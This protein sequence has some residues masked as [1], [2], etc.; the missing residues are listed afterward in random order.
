VTGFESVSL[1]NKAS[2]SRRLCV[3]EWLHS[4][5]HF[6][7]EQPEHYQEIHDLHEQFYRLASGVLASAL[8]GRTNEAKRELEAPAF[9][10]VNAALRAASTTTAASA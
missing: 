3:W 4:A 7:A 5:G 9:L 8:A 6:R 10:E 1:T 2:G